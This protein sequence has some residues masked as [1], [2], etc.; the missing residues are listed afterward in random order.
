M[1]FTVRIWSGWQIN[2]DCEI[3]GTRTTTIRASRFRVTLLQCFVKLWD[4]S[5]NLSY[6]PVSHFSIVFKQPVLTPSPCVLDGFEFSTQMSRAICLTAADSRT[7]DPVR[8]IGLSVLAQFRQLLVSD[9]LTSTFWQIDALWHLCVG[10]A[11]WTGHQSHL[12]NLI[13]IHCACLDEFNELK[14]GLVKKNIKNKDE[15]Q[16]LIDGVGLSC[17]ANVARA[18]WHL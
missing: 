4:T 8:H 9:L 11:P 1:K 13:I 7:W 5:D 12:L 18:V 10:C 2:L 3:S 15:M 16:T 6:Q 17:H 14:E